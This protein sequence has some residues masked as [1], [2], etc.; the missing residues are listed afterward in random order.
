MAEPAIAATW[1]ELKKTHADDRTDN[2]T[3][4]IDRAKHA[5]QAIRAVDLLIMHV[6]HRSR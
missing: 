5:L 4:G 2:D 6:I 3:C 1:E